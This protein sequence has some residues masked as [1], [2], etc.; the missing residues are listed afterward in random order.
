MNFSIR[1]SV[2]R[3]TPLTNAVSKKWSNHEAKMDLFFGVY[4]FCK[5]HGALKTTPAVA[6][7]LTDHVW[8]IRELLE[9]TEP[10][11]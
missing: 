9:K 3:M 2:R 7:G 11:H 4:D 5:I 8:T 10:T 1:M 6:A